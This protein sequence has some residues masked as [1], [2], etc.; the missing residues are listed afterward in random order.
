LE[1]WIKLHR[2]LLDNGWLKNPE[3]YTFWNYCLLRASHKEH[4]QM[5]GFKQVTLLPGQFVFGRKKAAEVLNTTESKIRTNIK[6]LTKLKSITIESTNAFSIITV[7]N[8]HRYQSS[9]NEVDQQ[10][11][12][13]MTS[14]SPADNH[15]QELKNEKMQQN[16][17]DISVTEEKTTHDPLIPVS[18]ILKKHRD[19][20]KNPETV[21]YINRF[22]VSCP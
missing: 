9:D 16:I 4:K 10:I 20:G 11:S 21:K 13:R 6:N 8:W 1:G 22:L 14:V 2:S 7:T 12:Q 17:K 3:L 19:Q 5:V 18:E 15:K